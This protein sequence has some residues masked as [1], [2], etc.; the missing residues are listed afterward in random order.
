[1]RAIQMSAIAKRASPTPSTFFYH[2]GFAS[3]I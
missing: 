2:H 3:V 1:L